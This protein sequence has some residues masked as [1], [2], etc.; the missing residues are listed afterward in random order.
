MNS[1]IMIAVLMLC[2]SVLGSNAQTTDQAAPQEQPQATEPAQ[3]P[4]QAEQPPAPVQQQAAPAAAAPAGPVENTCAPTCEPQKVRK[5]V[6]YKNVTKRVPIYAREKGVKKNDKCCTKPVETQPVTVTEPAPQ[7][8]YVKQRIVIVKVPEYIY[9]PTPPITVVQPRP[10]TFIQRQPVVVAPQPP[11][12]IVKKMVCCPPG[13][14]VA[15]LPPCKPGQISNANGNGMVGGGYVAGA[16]R[17]KDECVAR[18]GTDT[19]RG[20]DGWT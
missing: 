19:G 6:G 16:P 7:T 14:N 9:A 20:C 18:G 13:V 8:I 3:T 12:E 17:N 5:I 15:G 10:T 4:A 1:R 11:A 2:A